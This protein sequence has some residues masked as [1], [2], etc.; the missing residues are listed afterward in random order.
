MK[1][2]VLILAAAFAAAGFQSR[3]AARWERRAGEVEIVRDD[4]GI[5]HVRGKT[6]AAAV[7]GMVYAQA[8]DDFNRVETNYLNA[9]GRLAEA[10][11]EARI[12][13]DLRMKLFIAPAELQKQYRASPAWLRSLM[14]AFADGLNYYLAKHP[15][16]K[17]RAIRRFEPWMA[18]S[19]TEGSIG[20]D[21]ER[22]NLQQLQQFYGKEPVAMA[23]DEAPEEP[24]GSNGIAIGPANT[25]ARHALLLINPHTSFFFR[26]ELQMASE[27][28]LNAYGAVTWGQFFIYQGFNERAGWMH[29]S[30][31]VD[32]VDEYLETVAGKDG[33]YFYKFG[34]DERP[35]TATEIAV[36]YRTGGGM[37]EKKFTVYR[38]HHGPVIR[39]SGGKW[40]TIRLM[41]EPVK[42]LEQSYLRT[43]ARNYKAFRETMELRANSS[44]NTIFADA[45]G[46]IAYFHGNFIPRRNPAFDWTRP[47]DGS[48][49]ATDWQG[50][51]AVAETPQLLNP[52]SGWVYNAND[53][54]WSAAGADSPKKSGYPAYVE[55]GSESARGLHAMR[56]LENRSGFTLDTLAA[57]AY[58]PLL[59]WFEKPLPALVKAWDGAG[60]G[61]LR[62][63]VEEQIA[64]LR[65]WGLRWGVE[66][67]ATS[68]AVFWGEEARGRGAQEA[69]AAGLPVEE[70]LGTKAPGQML[71]ESLAAASDKLQSAFGT[72]KTQWGEINR[73]QRLTGDIAQPFHDS[74]KSLAV[75]FTSAQWGSLASFG[76]R[77]YPGTKKWYGTSGN[78]FVAVV[79]FGKT[80]RARAVTAG[81]ES[82]DPASRH[83]NDQAER[84][85]AGNLREVYFYPS[86]LQGHTEQTYR[87]GFART[88]AAV[89]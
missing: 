39:E 87:P 2:V 38:T 84:Y 33:R 66:S 53:W 31:G 73:F 86:Q 13:Q 83:F 80:V 72:W 30:S 20:G 34:A 23:T 4:W 22:I 16:V 51:H 85:A 88:Q 15:E 89:K 44:N 18:L 1:K 78:S 35:V 26:S 5:A 6:D 48:D 36:P 19:F 25:A 49:P 64:L 56:V 69:R 42:A 3:D 54:P 60:A 62:A 67:V 28:G 47:V 75:G 70:Y 24:R 65:R 45:D 81:G 74:G 8:E 50:L 77:A 59:T 55:S 57:A 21:I 41:Q 76:A 11:G 29:T 10:E 12:Y 79:E 61:P 63:K 43:K 71:L 37:A 9:L 7:F 14:N 17:P 27:E 58:D 32:A 52:R 40:V 46:N 68:L 82:G